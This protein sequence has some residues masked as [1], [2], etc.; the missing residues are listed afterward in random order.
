MSTQTQRSMKKQTIMIHALLI[1][2]FLLGQI[3]DT[4]AQQTKQDLE[5]L[6]PL[7]MYPDVWNGTKD[8]Y[9]WDWATE[10]QQKV[11]YFCG[12]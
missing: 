5:V 1:F 7:Y 8:I 3:N 4:N 10:A 2:T 11:K 12:D 6:I 9:Q